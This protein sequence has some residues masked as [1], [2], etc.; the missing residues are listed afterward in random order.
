MTINQFYTNLFATQQTKKVLYFLS[1]VF[2]LITPILFI[3][4][5]IGKF[6]NFRFLLYVVFFPM[7]SVTLFVE[8]LF[9][10]LNVFTNPLNDLIVFFSVDVFFWFTCIMIM[11]RGIKS[12]NPN[13]SK[14]L[15]FIFSL[16]LL[17]NS[18]SLYYKFQ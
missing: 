13:S 8:L 4:D 16:I 9:P 2:A 15:F 3:N 11:V 12:R 14:I 17:I 10:E 1:L 5:G 6:L 18:V 7:G